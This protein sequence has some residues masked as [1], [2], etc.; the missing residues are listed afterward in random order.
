[1]SSATNLPFAPL[2]IRAFTATTALGRGCD[3]QLDALRTRRG[4][5][6]R[7]DFT[8]APPL[9]TWIGRVEGLEEAP[10]PSRWSA[11]ECRNNRLAWLALQQD[12]L[13]EAVAALRHRHGTARVAIVVG[14]STAS[15][16]ATE[17]A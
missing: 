2:A 1:L 14:T 8:A 3:A 5:L 10:L 11:W 17:E 13:A 9:D 12:G 4:G 6:R 7:N 16:G 15:I